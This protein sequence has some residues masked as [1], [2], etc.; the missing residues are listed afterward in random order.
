M[1]PS[2]VLQALRQLSQN[3]VAHICTTFSIQPQQVIEAK[4][5]PAS[6]FSSLL[7]RLLRVNDAAHAAAR[8]LGNPPDRE[9]MIRD[10]KAF[11]DPQ[12]IVDREL[13]CFTPQV[14]GILSTDVVQL[15]QPTSS[16]RDSLSPGDGTSTESVLDLWT[17]FLS[18]LPSR[19]PRARADPRYFNICLG[20]VASAALRDL[21]TNGAISFGSWWVVRCWI[22]EW[23]G[24]LAERGGFLSHSVNGTRA[25]SDA[26]EELCHDDSGVSLRGEEPTSLL[27]EVGDDRDNRIVVPAS[28]G[29]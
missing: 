7:N 22:D 4:L 25:F 13:P 9:Q 5:G 17:Q 15:L 10:W 3:L 2:F 29:K 12:T 24:W 20:S 28:F 11:V 8:F 1:V 14:V 16:L 18:N 21:T 26:A 23:M 19:F 27:D 6:I